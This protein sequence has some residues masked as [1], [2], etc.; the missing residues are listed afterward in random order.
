LLPW[1]AATLE[2]KAEIARK[3]R[4]CRDVVYTAASVTTIKEITLNRFAVFLLLC[5]LAGPALAEGPAIVSPEVILTG[6]P[7]D[8]GVIEN[9]EGLNIWLNGQEISGGEDGFY[10]D[11]KLEETGTATIE[12]YQGAK[13]LEARELPVIPGWVSI[14]PPLAAILLA[15][16]LRSVIPALFIGLLV[17]AWAVN[18]LGWA[19]LFYGFFETLTIYTVRAAAD[20]TH[21]TIMLFTF[22]IG[23]MVGIISRNGGM[24]GI[25][26]RVMPYASSPRRGQ[27]IV[28]MLGLAIFFDDYANTLIVG[29]TARPVTDKLKISREKLAYLVDS[30]AAPISTVAIIT[31]WIGFQ[32][33]LI[34]EA[35]QGLE[36]LSESAY[37]LFLQSI[38]FSFYPFLAIFFV[39]LIVFSGKDFGAMW[40]AEKRARTTGLL[41]ANDDGPRGLESSSEFATKIGITGK[42]RNA[43]IPILT[44]VGGVV[45]GLFVSG[46]GDNIQDILG[47]ADSYAVLMWASL[48]SVFVAAAMSIGQGV[49]SLNETVD[50]WIEG[51]K[52]MLTGLILLVLAWAV[53]DVA[54]VVQTA[55]YLISVLGDS[56]TPATLPAIVFLLAAASAFASGS[57]WGVMAILMPLVIPLCWAV[58]LNHG[59]ATEQHMH[60]LYSCIACV[61][62]GAVWADHC[63]PISD[64]TVLSSIATGCDHM[65]HVRTQM[66]YA[67]LAG[68]VALLIGVLPAGFGLP[69]WVMMA[70]S[71]VVLLVVH[72][73]LAQPIPDS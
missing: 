23:G 8:V 19:G 9:T 63:S 13:L 20:E 56:L 44:L 41:S 69:W 15:F 26:N 34:D 21:M 64:T 61:L 37:A 35:I 16:L 30:T 59:M 57:S 50:A 66:P 67:L 42:A 14:T 39:F 7:F 48:L 51:T 46:E 17:G 2:L 70:V 47:S 27:G 65:D 40:R 32:V 1:I 60:I 53:A 6:V 43:V 24:V 72:R 12:L 33:G 11:L 38:P 18:G 31:T 5:V 10:P 68:S 45:V 36:G 55:P 54:K 62:T 29:N 71:C 25:V 58:L 28:A 73:F 3:A 22:M 49:L 52:F 4:S